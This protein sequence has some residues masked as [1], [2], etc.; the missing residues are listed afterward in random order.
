MHPMIKEANV[1]D[2]EQILALQKLAYISEAEIYN[3]FSIEPLVQSI[4]SVHEQFQHF[5]F[6]KA[7]ANDG[8]IVGSVRARSIEDICHIGKLIVH[9][10][11]QNKGIG[12]RLLEGI[13]L[14]FKQSSKYSLYTGSK[15]NKNIQFYTRLGYKIVSTKP[16]HDQLSLVYLEK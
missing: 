12:R 14:A 13:E 15:S 2:S 1:S 10:N 6:L 4:E 9:P 5:I 3:D 7:V 16:I 8:T 11:F